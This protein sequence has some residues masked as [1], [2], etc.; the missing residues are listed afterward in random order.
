[1]AN[2][3][4]D[5]LPEPSCA[6][7]GFLVQANPPFNPATDESRNGHAWHLAPPPGLNMFWPYPSI[8]I[9]ARRQRD[10]PRLVPPRK[11]K[12]LSWDEG[13]RQAYQERANEIAEILSEQIQ[14]NEFQEFSMLYSPKEHA[15]MLTHKR[16]LE[17]Q[18]EQAKIR[19]AWEA[20]QEDKRDKRQDD[21]DERQR[22][23]HSNLETEMSKKQTKPQWWLFWIALASIIV[24]PASSALAV[25]WINGDSEPPVVNNQLVIPSGVTPLGPVIATASIV[26]SFEQSTPDTPTVTN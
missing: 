11:L 20:E 19:Q 5:N 22:T 24:G 15:D 16:L 18:E 14:C 9:C 1:M 3:W 23:W 21:R 6:K 25:K 7:C 2:D 26:P 8:P 17:F 12:L 13:G 4:W 10:I